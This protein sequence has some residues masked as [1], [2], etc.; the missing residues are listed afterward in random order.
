MCPTYV[1]DIFGLKMFNDFW[2][3]FDFEWHGRLECGQ[4]PGGL[5]Q[6]VEHQRLSSFRNRIVSMI[7]NMAQQ[8]HSSV[9]IDDAYPLPRM[10]V[11]HGEIEEKRRFSASGLADDIDMPGAVFRRERNAGAGRRTRDDGPWRSILRNSARCVARHC[12][13]V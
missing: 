4:K 2:R 7:G 8:S 11:L 12:S 6:I 1:G 13:V 3:Q 9:R 5:L 10:D